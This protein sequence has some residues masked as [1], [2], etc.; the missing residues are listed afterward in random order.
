MFF[1]DLDAPKGRTSVIV[2]KEMG[3]EFWK[4][5]LRP[6]HGLSTDLR[7]TSMCS[8]IPWSLQD[9]KLFM[10]GSVSLHGLCTT[11]VSRRFDGYRG[12]PSLGPAE[13]LSYGDSGKGLAQYPSSC[14]PS[15]R[16][17]NLY[18]VC[19]DSDWPCLASLYQHSFGV[20]LS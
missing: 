7:I 12:L 5:N 13:T 1:I 19:P 2:Q 10:L 6:T 3:C 4:N 8:T 17:T 15:E 14:Q 16:L 11:D 9:E 20:E 18:R